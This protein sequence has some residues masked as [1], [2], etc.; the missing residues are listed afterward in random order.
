MPGEPPSCSRTSR[1]SE[2]GQLGA[3]PSGALDEPAAVP[4]R[5][6]AEPAAGLD[7]AAFA[8]TAGVAQDLNAGSVAES[9]AMIGPM[10]LPGCLYLKSDI[11]GGSMTPLLLLFAVGVSSLPWVADDYGKALAD[12]KARH[13]PLFV[14]VWAPW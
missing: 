8:Q 13:V 9:K 12:A 6:R 5:A 2:R 14:E 3:L 11:F 7:T 1:R 4:P 10:T